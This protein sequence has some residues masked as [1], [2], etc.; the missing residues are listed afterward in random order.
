MAENN[1]TVWSEGMFLRPQHFQQHDRYLETLVRQRCSG[2]QPYDWGFKTLKIDTRHLGMGKFSLAGCS[3][4]FPDGT[5]FNLPGDDDLPLPIDIP[6]DVQQAIIYLSLPTLR[7]GSVETDTDE[8]P[9]N[10]ARYHADEQ[11]VRDANVATN[12]TSA[13]VVAKLHTRLMLEKQE[14]AGYVCIGVARVVESRLDKNIILDDNYIP[15]NLD[16]NAIAH[17]KGYIKELSGLLHTRGEALGGRASEAGRGGVA[18]ISDYMLLQLVNR[19]EPLFGHLQNIPNLH[20]ESFYRLAVQLAGELST[21]CKAN[22]RPVSFSAYNHDDLQQTFKQVMDELRSLLSSVL[23][24]NAIFIPLT[25]PK[26]GIRGAKIPDPNLLKDAIFVLAVNAQVS[27]E[28]LRSGFASQVKIGPVEQINQLIRNV[29][30]GIT[31]HALPVAP[32]QIP[33][34]AGFT[35]FELNKQSELWKQMQ[36]SGGFAIHIAGEFPGLEL[37]FWA[38]KNG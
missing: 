29:L 15:P 30:P 17:T 38:I 1:K 22:K 35:Y 31:I 21:F 3:G 10:L 9:S 2:L 12:A 13:V 4:I 23:E 25:A 37:E 7:P 5:P 18:E 32:R 27:P 14:R 36:Q 28:Q 6:T 33:Y 11:Q 8:N 26:F 34:H 19:M 16:C 24:Q 20:P